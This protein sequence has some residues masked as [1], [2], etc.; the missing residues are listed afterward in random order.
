M[1]PL[2]QTKGGELGVRT[3]IIPDLQSSL[4]LWMLNQDSELL[5][6]GDAGT[7]NRAGRAAARASSGSTTT[8]RGPGCS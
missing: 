8:G 3:E 6:V 2:V 1:N 4:A 7:T 5:F